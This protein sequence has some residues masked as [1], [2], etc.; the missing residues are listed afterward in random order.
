[1][2]GHIYYTHKIIIPLILLLLEVI[3]E[4]VR[5]GEWIYRPL[6]HTTRNYK[7]LQRHR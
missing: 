3:K 5:I 6:I 7:Q 1:M 2:Y 4:G